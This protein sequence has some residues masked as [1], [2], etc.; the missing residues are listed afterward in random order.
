MYSKNSTTTH[1]LTTSTKSRQTR[2]R[3]K[4]TIYKA[5]DKASHL[6][7]MSCT[8][9]AFGLVNQAKMKKLIDGN[10]CMA[11]KNLEARYP[12][13]CVRPDPAGKRIQQM[14]AKPQL[15]WFRKMA[16]RDW[17][18]STQDDSNQ[19]ASPS[20]RRRWKWL[21][22]QSKSLQWNS[23][24]SFWR[25]LSRSWEQLASLNSRAR[26]ERSKNKSLRE[27]EEHKG[28]CSIHTEVK[29][30]CKTCGK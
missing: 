10:A 21:R 2:E 29:R 1:A 27:F 4:A 3:V 13:F 26:S 16:H 11:L 25:L 30:I 17:P 24:A 14:Q 12:P 6:L 23:T 20:R 19:P 8:G 18:I 9:I 7:I 22:M 28:D 15:L 5:N